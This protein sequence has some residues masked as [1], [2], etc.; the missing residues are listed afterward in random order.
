MFITPGM[1]I[2]AVSSWIIS[3]RG[4]YHGCTA[5][6]TGSVN[7]LVHHIDQRQTSTGGSGC[8]GG[9][10]AKAGLQQRGRE[11]SRPLSHGRGCSACI[12]PAPAFSDAEKGIAAAWGLWGSTGATGHHGAGGSPGTAGPRR[13]LCR[14]FYAGSCR[15]FMRHVHT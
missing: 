5:D 9:A 13:L 2:T 6:R 14:S 11:G 4:H 8:P 1:G 15:G 12:L 10:M 7:T 3:G